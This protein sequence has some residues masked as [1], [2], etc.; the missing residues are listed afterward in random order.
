MQIALFTIYVQKFLTHIFRNR[1][2]IAY[3][4]AQEYKK[5]IGI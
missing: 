3:Y 4:V 1:P 2:R 5:C